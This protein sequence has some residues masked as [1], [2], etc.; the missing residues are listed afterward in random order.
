MKSIII[1]MASSIKITDETKHE[2]DRLLANL[3]VKYDKKFTQQELIHL[4]IKFGQANMELLLTPTRTPSE[5]VMDKIKK[6][7]KPWTI[8][9][10]PE[11]I[12]EILYGETQS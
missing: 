10:D 1:C 6:L 12:D 11:K 8:K 2:L 5:N 4:L 7:Q 9:T 3:M